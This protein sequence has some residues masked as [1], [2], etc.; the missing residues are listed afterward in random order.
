[1]VTPSGVSLEGRQV[2]RSALRRG[3]SSVCYGGVDRRGRRSR[4][5]VQRQSGRTRPTE[6]ST[7]EYD[8]W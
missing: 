7:C 4:Q 6:R 5:Q 8:K 1:M 2:S 3:M